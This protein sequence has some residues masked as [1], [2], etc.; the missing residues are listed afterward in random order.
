[1]SEY[2]Y[3][4]K[5]TGELLTYKQMQQ[6]GVELYD[7]N[8]PTNI[9]TF[10]D[11]YER[12]DIKAITLTEQERQEAKEALYKAVDEIAGGLQ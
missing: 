9:F 5:E 7:L 11:Y 1:M 3:R 4:N 12:T 8:D 6:E 2:L 10:S